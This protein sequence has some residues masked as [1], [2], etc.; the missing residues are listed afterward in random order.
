MFFIILSF[1]IFIYA[2]EID[3][4]EL[5]IST[6]QSF[7]SKRYLDST[8]KYQGK[9]WI[10][11]KDPKVVKAVSSLGCRYSQY[12]YLP[13]SEGSL[14]TYAL[15]PFKYKRADNITRGYF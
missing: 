15:M 11:V 9:I 4:K 6:V 2:E 12:L 14:L 5:K 3:I 1:T 13:S 7:S 8:L 10:T